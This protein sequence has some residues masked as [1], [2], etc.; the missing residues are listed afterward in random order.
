M[1]ALPRQT[2]R[3]KPSPLDLRQLLRN[4][5][6]SQVREA[7]ASL[8]PAEALALQYDWRGLW[9]RPEQ[10]APPGDWST[11]LIKC[12][13]GWGKT[14]TGAEWIVEKERLGARYITLVGATPAD[15]RDIMIEGESGILAVAPPDRR[16]I[17]EPSKLRLTWPSGAVAVIRSGYKPD[18]L[19]GVQSEVA[20][21]DELASWKYPES[22]DQLQFG[23]R[24]GSNPQAV[25]TTTPRPTPVIKRLI[26]DPTTRVTHGSTYDNRVNLAERFFSAV[27]RKYEGTRLG[28]QELLGD[29]LDD[30]PGAL[31]KR[32]EH[33]DPFRVRV[34][35]ELRRVIVAVDPAVT[36]N[37]DSDETGIIVVGLGV[38]GHGYVLDDASGIWTPGQWADR[39]YYKWK[40]FAADL[41]VGEVNNGG[42]LVEANLRAHD[43]ERRNVLAYK[44]V[45]ASRGKVTRAEPVQALYEQGRIHHVGSLA[46][47]ED[48]MC[49]WDPRVDG[50]SPD[51]LDALVW[52]ITELMLGEIDVPGSYAGWDQYEM[53][54]LEW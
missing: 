12:G 33:L 27:I 52:G 32:S 5:T 26:A 31:W 22:W 6:P 54:K 15:C 20:W 40:E 50:K 49:G 45:R 44:A 41:V 16:P 42:D 30:N 46:T 29:V 23:L 14:R 48:Q 35:P 9:A 43:H 53:P 13:R 51:R 36:A 38:D 19:R 18:G 28:R 3:E 24:L 4:A 25:V 7:I 34:A 1:S 8:S 37:E 10:L 47:L 21:C 39:V 2:M 17:Y 11:W